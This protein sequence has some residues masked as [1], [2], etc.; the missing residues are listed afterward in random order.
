MPS[1]DPRKGCWGPGGLR[2]LCSN[3]SRGLGFLG[4]R[5]FELFKGDGSLLSPSFF[6]KTLSFCLLVMKAVAQRNVSPE[7]QD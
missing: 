3:D 2:Q 5:Q 4:Y 7:F 1:W 6:S